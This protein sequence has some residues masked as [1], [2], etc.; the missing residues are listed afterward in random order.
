MKNIESDN[1]SPGPFLICLSMMLISTASIVV[2][3]IRNRKNVVATEQLLRLL[4]SPCRQYVLD[5]PRLSAKLC[6]EP[7]RFTC[8][9]GT[10]Q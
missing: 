8:N 10:R 6:H 3:S 9:I 4:T 1:Y 2:K 7:S 5:S